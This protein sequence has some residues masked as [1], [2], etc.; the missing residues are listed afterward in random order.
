MIRCAARFVTNRRRSDPVSDVLSCDLH[1]LG[2]TQLYKR[3]ILLI[4]YKIINF[5]HA[6]VFFKDLFKDNCSVHSYTTRNRNNLHLSVTPATEL[7][8]FCISYNGVMLWNNCP[9]MK[10]LSLFNFKLKLTEHLLSNCE[11]I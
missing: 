11:R 7:G 10:N 5:S 2:P 9:V 8:K 6:P 1:W 4:M 3:A